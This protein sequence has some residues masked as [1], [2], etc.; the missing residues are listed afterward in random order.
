MYKREL[1][2]ERIVRVIERPHLTDVEQQRINLGNRRV[3]EVLNDAINAF[4][5]NRA[6][7]LAGP[8]I[9]HF[10]HTVDATH[11][12]AGASLIEK[13]LLKMTNSRAL[14]GEELAQLFQLI[15]FLERRGLSSKPDVFDS[16]LL[17]VASNL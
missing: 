17:N 11:D 1:P 10:L 16:I 9:T 8:F 6:A 3:N 7:R 12:P 4:S 13:Y 14:Y 2:H 5:W 15:D